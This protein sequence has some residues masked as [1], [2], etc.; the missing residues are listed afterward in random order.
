MCLIEGIPCVEIIGTGGNTGHAWNK[1]LID[2]VWYGV[3]ATWSRM[4]SD[5]VTLRYLLI[6]EAQLIESGH[7]ENNV[8]VSP[9]EQ[10][11]EDYITFV[12]SSEKDYYEMS[13]RVI[14]SA[15]DIKELIDSAA[16]EGITVLELKNLTGESLDQLF[17]R[18]QLSDF[19]V[20]SLSYSAVNGTD[21]VYIMFV[22]K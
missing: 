12:A 19:N 15:E 18:Y 1:L 11:P 22:L 17:R 4:G 3:D 5:L 13:G 6:N 9:D 8:T 20:E 2:G 21:T 16:A 10:A 14:R 7:L